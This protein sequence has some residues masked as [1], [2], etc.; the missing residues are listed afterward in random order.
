VE[1]LERLRERLESAEDLQSIVKTMK[2][3]SAVAIRQFEQAAQ[4][5]QDYD[6]AVTLGLRAALRNLPP[7]HADTDAQHRR[8][9]I[10]VAFGSDQGMCGQLNDRVARA[11][12]E[13]PDT[14]SAD[15][16]IPV[17]VVGDR[18]ASLLQRDDLH[19]LHRLP[20]PASVH[21]VS[22][23]ASALL[24]AIEPARAEHDNAPVRLHF[25]RRT[26]AAAYDI[27]DRR[28][29]PLDARWL[30]SLAEEPWPSRC[31]PMWTGD[32]RDVLRRLVREYLFASLSRAL[33]D[34]LAAAHASRLASM[35]SAERNI[36]QRIDELTADF[37]RTRQNAITSELM[38]VVSGFEALADDA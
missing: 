11:I 7:E 1:S 38:D 12:T 35:Q 26:S 20:T 18:L 25:P 10:A 8:Q 30:A 37:R 4:S 33:V 22:D 29:L 9:H 32:R 6:R 27:H 16:P 31:I 23:T 24:E 21:A 15:Q 5:M 13:Q 2:A 14:D 19:T 34:T 17:I 36:E 3:L 28:V